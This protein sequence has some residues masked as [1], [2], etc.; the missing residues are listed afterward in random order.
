MIEIF[1]KGLVFE[2]GYG[3]EWHMGSAARCN[4][5]KSGFK[6]QA[7]AVPLKF[8]TDIHNPPDISVL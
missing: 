1:F 3:V 6:L 2:G 8:F 4:F 7:P 5:I